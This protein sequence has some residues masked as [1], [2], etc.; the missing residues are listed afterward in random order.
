[1]CKEAG[2][3]TTNQIH[4]KT[5]CVVATESAINGETQRIRKAWKKGI[6]VVHLAWVRQCIDE[7]QLRPFGDF[8]VRPSG[9]KKRIKPT[10]E[11]STA[12]APKDPDTDVKDEAWSEPVELGCCCLCHDTGAGVTDCEWC[13]DCGVNVAAKATKG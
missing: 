6:P 2:A 1:L 12:K 11:E 9:P 7:E 3:G 10:G 13:V 4:K 8:L 5:F